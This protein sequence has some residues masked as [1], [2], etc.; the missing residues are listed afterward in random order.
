MD[1]EHPDNILD[2]LHLN[3]WNAGSDRFE[4]YGLYADGTAKRRGY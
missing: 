1:S 4:S 2:E 3:E